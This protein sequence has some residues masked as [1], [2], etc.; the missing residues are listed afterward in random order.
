MSI[1]LVH[2]LLNI[3][4]I[5][6]FYLVGC[7]ILYFLRIQSSNPLIRQYFSLLCGFLFVVI[8]WAIIMTSGKTSYLALTPFFIWGISTRNKRLK[9]KFAIFEKK[10]LSIF[11]VTI[12]IFSFLTTVLM[13]SK[14]TDI[15]HPDLSV[16]HLH[17]DYVFYS[18]VA[19]HLNKVCAENYQ[20]N[21][22][23]ESIN[24]Y[25]FSE[26][27]LTSLLNKISN[28][29]YIQTFLFQTTPLLFAILWFGYF[30]TA[31]TI[32]KKYS[33]FKVAILSTICFVLAPYAFL[34]NPFNSI[35]RGDVYD[36]IFTN[37]YK[38]SI[39]HLFLIGLVLLRNQPAYSIIVLGL[40]G[41][42]YP[43][44]L[45]AIIAT[46]VL[47]VIYF[48][49]K[50]E[51]NKVEFFKLSLYWLSSVLILFM[52]L[53]LLSAGRYPQVES[54]IFA[55][56]IVSIPDYIKTIINI[57]GSTFL[58]ISISCFPYILLAIVLYK[59][60]QQSIKNIFIVALLIFQVSGLLA[61][62]LLFRMP[63][64][65]QLWFNIYLP[66][67]NTCIFIL[68]ILSI[69]DHRPWVKTFSISLIFL[70]VVFH[71]P[72]R[73]KYH[74][75]TFEENKIIQYV[76]LTTNP[77]F[78]YIKDTNE[79]KSVFDKNVNFAIIANYI[80]FYTTSYA[81]VC[82]NT[83]Q[84]P[85]NNPWEKEFVNNSPFAE[86]ASLKTT[87]ISNIQNEY[88][89]TFNTKFLIASENAPLP[90]FIE[91]IKDTIINDRYNKVKFI[92][93]K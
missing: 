85:I 25:H 49:L 74:H 45:P 48:H 84:I 80:S 50:N 46:I 64:S 21:S 47:L 67:I 81:P 86:F 54:S 77:H 28:K 90:S 42:V 1:I 53:K 75:I 7:L 43:T 4:T 76:K 55:K 29:P 89:K 19:A 61:W 51:Q 78:V 36:L 14:Y 52:L 37:Y 71:F 60:T 18:N 68:L 31:T 93:L 66:V 69:E 83:N 57:V 59:K 2:T 44:T 56:Y 41:I 12:S 9:S 11:V 8:V 32:L 5:L 20:I 34:V 92:V 24:L 38:L 16:P 22:T 26:I 91:S 87:G 33:K 10:D 62:A 35:L 6:L 30:V 3:V 72:E 58:K 15:N 88:T 82:I 17:N 27:W 13:V 65:V 39:I 70:N 23:S 73:N 63:D 79:F 40:L